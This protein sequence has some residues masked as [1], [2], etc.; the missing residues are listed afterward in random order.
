MEIGSATLSRHI[1]YLNIDHLQKLA[2]EALKTCCLSHQEFILYCIA[3]DSVWRDVVDELHPEG[4]WQP[5]RSRG[6]KPVAIGATTWDQLDPFLQSLPNLET[7][8]YLPLGDFCV[9]VLILHDDGFALAE[10]LALP[11]HRLS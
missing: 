7:L 10:I 5:I 3:V 2:L 11:Y 6:L 4:D 9:R 8:K 1:F